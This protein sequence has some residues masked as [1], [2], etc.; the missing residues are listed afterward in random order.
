MK[1]QYISPNTKVKVFSFERT[2]LMVDVTIPKGDDVINPEDPL[3]SKDNHFN[4]WEE[5]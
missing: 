2:G 3:E 1:K 4:V 5:D